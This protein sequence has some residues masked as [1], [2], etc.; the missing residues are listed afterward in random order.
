[1]YGAEWNMLLILPYFSYFLKL[2]IIIF[3]IMCVIQIIFSEQ[4]HFTSNSKIKIQVAENQVN[5][6]KKKQLSK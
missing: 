4:H 2:T 1:M 6:T 3:K 5:D